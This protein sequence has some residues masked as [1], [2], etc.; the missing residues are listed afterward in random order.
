MLLLEQRLMPRDLE[1]PWVGVGVEVAST[2]P[3][4]ARSLEVDPS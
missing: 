4:D 1:I 3:T 2:E